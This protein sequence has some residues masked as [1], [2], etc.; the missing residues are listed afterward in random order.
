MLL[1]NSRRRKTMSR[2]EYLELKEAE[3]LS[4]QKAV[5]PEVRTLA[6]N[7][8][9]KDSPKRRLLPAEKFCLTVE[10]AA[11]Y[12]EIGEKKIRRLADLHRD[13]GLFTRH[14][15]KVLVHRTAFENFL[16]QTSDI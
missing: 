7:D 10:E 15:V 13:D 11:A 3:L 6:E 4:N 14:G 9:V 2:N 16:L 8:M 1:T 12:F 5:M